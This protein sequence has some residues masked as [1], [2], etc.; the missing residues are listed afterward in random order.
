MAENDDVEIEEGENQEPPEPVCLRCLRP[1][2]P[3]F[4][5]CPHCGEATGRFTTYLPFESIPWE[6]RI[7]GRMWRQ[8]WSRNVSLPGRLLRLLMILWA[9]PVLLVGLFFRHR[10]KAEDD[11][12]DKASQAKA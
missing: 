12:P 6:T 1:V 9:A 2:E 11:A 5:Y 10:Q 8:L 3:V 7:W 4:H